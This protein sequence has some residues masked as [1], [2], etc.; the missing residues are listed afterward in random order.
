MPIMITPAQS[1]TP[2]KTT[3][4][5]TLGY[6]VTVTV[7]ETLCDGR[8]ITLAKAHVVQ[9]GESVYG[10]PDQKG[11]V[12]FTA[13]RE[14]LPGQVPITASLSAVEGCKPSPARAA[15]LTHPSSPVTHVQALKPASHG[16]A[17]LVGVITLLVAVLLVV[18][19]AMAVA[20]RLKPKGVHHQ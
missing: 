9:S 17:G 5:N 16:D 18:A 1:S 19:A 13:V 20:K 6:P 15:S 3:L 7:K 12:T 10:Y 2:T 14:G 4:T 11:V 8:V